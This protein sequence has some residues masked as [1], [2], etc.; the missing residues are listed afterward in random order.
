MPNGKWEPINCRRVLNVWV[1]SC[2]NAQV[3]GSHNVFPEEL[4]IK[5]PLPV[6]SLPHY[7]H[8]KHHHQ[9]METLDFHKTKPGVVDVDFKA[10]DI[11]LHGLHNIKV[12][13]LNHWSWWQH[14]LHRLRI[15]TSCVIWVSR[16]SGWFFRWAALQ[17]PTHSVSL[18]SGPRPL[19]DQKFL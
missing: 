13:E 3:P 16:I 15:C 11:Q 4:L 1:A 10:W 9:V 19:L 7:H 8:C 2:R 12:Q 5:D 6:S 17:N 14:C 18:L